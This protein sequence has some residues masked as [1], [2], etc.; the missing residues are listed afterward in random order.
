LPSPRRGNRDIRDTN[1]SK[2]AFNACSFFGTA[3]QQHRDM[4]AATSRQPRRPSLYA[5]DEQTGSFVQQT[6][7]FA[8]AAPAQPRR[9][10]SLLVAFHLRLRRAL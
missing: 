4:R 10:H 1:T 2:H 6:D 3:A 7:F 5:R 9:H 8:T